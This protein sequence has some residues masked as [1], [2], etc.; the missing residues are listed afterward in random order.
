M[1]EI[2]HVLLKVSGIAQCCVLLR[3]RN[4]TK[5]DKD[6]YLVCYYT[7][8]SGAEEL[9]KDHIY[10]ELANFLPDYMIPNFF[11]KLDAFP[12]T[13]NG[14]LDKKGLPLPDF[15]S[16]EENYVA[17]KTPIELD[18]CAIWEDVLNVERVG[19]KD[20]FFKVGGNSI[21]AIRAVKKMN[22]VLPQ[23]LSIRDLFLKATIRE[24][25]R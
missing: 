1:S 24:L 17:P 3:E 7:L 5:E 2:E 18:I 23:K 14:K 12:L 16:L 4:H 15:R 9:S 10:N 6:K 8:A 20:D 22:E 11:L 19:V 21:L 13:S 25:L